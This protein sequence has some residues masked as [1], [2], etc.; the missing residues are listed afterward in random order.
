MHM[1]AINPSQKHLESVDVDTSDDEEA[2]TYIHQED[3]TPEDVKKR[4]RSWAFTYFVNGSEEDVLYKVVPCQYMV[5]GYEKCPTTGKDH[6]QGTV[7]FTDAKT[8]SAAKKSLFGSPH[9]SVVKNLEKSIAYCKKGGS[10]FEKGTPP[11][12]PK[13][14]GDGERERWTIA[15]NH[16][17]EGTHDAI[18]S[19]IQFVY[20]RHIDYI[21]NKA[22]LAKKVV[23]TT[24]ENDWFCGPTGSGKS[25]TARETYPDAYLKSCNKWWDGYTG[26][27]VVIV[28]D[29]DA[30]HSVLC[31][32][33]KI[34][35]DRYPFPAEV[36]GGTMKIRPRKIIVTSNYAPNVIWNLDADLQPILR[37]FRVTEFEKFGELP[38]VWYN[39]GFAYKEKTV[40]NGQV[41]T[42]KPASIWGPGGPPSQGIMPG[43]PPRPLT[44]IPATPEEEVVP[45]APKR[46]RLV[47][48]SP[49]PFLSDGAM[50]LT[51]ACM[52]EEDEAAEA[53]LLGDP[54]DVTLPLDQ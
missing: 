27:E 30:T 29:F 8:F 15:L 12:T 4:Y 48:V 38:L 52:E 37:R 33:M 32:H 25:R 51:Q 16:A 49:V 46:A 34:W 36:K 40:P 44:P 22:Q 7:V 47:K 18:E 3:L 13:E 20:A 35:A 31:H 10:F 2:S 28:E 1:I 26:Q 24:I 14:K 42:F 39:T 21:H 53:A 50:Q 23:D 5:F 43:I 11:V 41:E 17:R 19:R 54:N 6:L 9:L 45:N